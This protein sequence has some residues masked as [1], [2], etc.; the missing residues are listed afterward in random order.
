MSTTYS[1]VNPAKVRIA[2]IDI[3][4]GLV[5]L[6]MLV[7]HV[8]ER[9]YLH[10]QVSDPMVIED[11][12]A[13]LFFSRLAA[14]FCAPVF[15]FLTGLSA[16]LYANP[17]GKPAR[18]ASEFLVKRGLFLILLEVT[19]INFSWFGRYD[20]LYLQVMWAI[21]LSMIALAAIIHLPFR[22]VGFLGAVIVFG[23]NALTPIAFVPGEWGYTAWTILHD[24]GYILHSDWLNIKISY[25]V[26]PWI[27]VIC[28]GYVAGPLFSAN[29]SAQSRSK[30]L[31]QMGIAALTLLLVIRGFNLYG[32][33]LPWVAGTDTMQTLM[34]F[35]NFTKYPPSLDFIL[36]TLGVALP[37][38]AI[39]EK[40]DNTST[41]VLKTFGAAPMFYYIVHLYVLLVLYQLAYVLIGPNYGNYVGVNGLHWVWG[42]TFALAM[43]LYYPTKK[44]A[45]FK[46]GSKH[47][48]LKYL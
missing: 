20:N 24:R 22:W 7:D 28:L 2:S 6:I 17:P 12:S 43:L 48:L 39:L 47:P 33:T 34:S 14:H 45:Q 4:R 23:H 35:L 5:M 26:L 19:L 44:F 42:I 11:T 25:P 38:L 30:W 41:E 16:W 10:M 3:L 32:E 37:V 21:G 29:T 8:R 46:H 27:G 31:W 15:V 1:N 40:M 36:L 18:S 9:F 13:G